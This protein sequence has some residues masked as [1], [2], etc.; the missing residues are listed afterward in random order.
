L[1]QERNWSGSADFDC[2][3]IHLAQ[4]DE[5]YKISDAKHEQIFCHELVHHLLY[6]AGAAINHELKEDEYIHLKE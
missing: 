4:R 2:D 5:S 6:H 3:E 1:R